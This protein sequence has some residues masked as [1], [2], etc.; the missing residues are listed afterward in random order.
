[1]DVNFAG[2]GYAFTRADILFDPVLEVEQVTLDQHTVAASYIRTFELLDRSARVD[3]IVPFVDA[4]WE[5][6]LRGEPAT[7]QR[8]GLGD[9]VGRFSINLAGGPP[10]RG[11]DFARYRAAHPDYTIV[12]AGIAVQAPL[13]NYLEDKLLNIG[14]N[15]FV[16]RPAIGVVRT[17]GKWSGELTGSVWFYSDN[18]SFWNGNR[19][20]QDPLPMVQAHLIYTFRP[21]LWVS[22]SAGYAHGGESFINGVAK[23]DTRDNLGGAL[24]FGYPIS[25]NVGIKVTYIRLETQQDV[26]SNSDTLLTAV[27]A[28]W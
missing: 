25:R 18:D 7:V 28:L 6:L 4:H 10:L 23:D 12:G 9:P 17:Q 11:A 3:L 8:Q 21:G 19:R 26:G 16:L 27:S 24:S 20:E 22:A 15:R 13:G 14:E 1:M 2:A 5:G